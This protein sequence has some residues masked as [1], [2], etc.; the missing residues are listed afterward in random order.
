MINYKY[1]ILLILL[2]LIVYSIQDQP[3]DDELQLINS[4]LQKLENT[5]DRIIELRGMKMNYLSLEINYYHNMNI[6]Q[7]IFHNFKE[8]IM[9]LI[10]HLRNAWF[11][12]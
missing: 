9:S 5:L 12:N 10:K 8:T 6:F 3:N 7:K 11:T 4:S 2:C 1:C